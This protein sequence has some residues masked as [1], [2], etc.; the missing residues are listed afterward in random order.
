MD[1]V[2]YRTMEEYM[3]SCMRDSAH[4]REHIYRVLYNALMIAK[5]ERHVDYDV[6]V[7]SCL[8]HDIARVDQFSNPEI[9]HATLGGEKAFDFLVEHGFAVDFAEKVKHCIQTHR[10]RKNCE[11]ESLEAKIL[12][13]A[14]KLDAAGAIGLARTLIYKGFVSEPIYRV[15]PDGTVSDG[16]GDAQP[17]FFQEYRYK[18]EKIYSTF[19]TRSGKELAGKRRNTAVRFYEDLLKEV[20]EMYQCGQEELK[21]VLDA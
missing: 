21:Q 16:A 5:S 8:L 14:D 19:Y 1:Q 11:P 6:L 3:L 17:S 20:S 2:Q 13:D 10:Y 15:L 12:F 9:C 4:D 7:A 18:L